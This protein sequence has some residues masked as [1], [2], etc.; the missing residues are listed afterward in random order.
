LNRRLDDAG[1]LRFEYRIEAVGELPVPIPNEK[2]NRLRSRAECPCDLPRLLSDPLGVWMG[3]A[4]SEVHGATGD[5]DEEQHVQT[6]QP[7]R[8]DREEIHRDHT[9]RLRPQELAPRGPAPPSSRSELFLTQRLL[10]GRRRYDDAEPFQFTNDTLVAP[11]RIF[12]SEPKD[13]RSHLKVDRRSPGWSAVRPPFRDEA[14]VP[15]EQR[16]GRNEKGS[17][18]QS[19]QGPTRCR[20]E[21]S[22]S[23]PKRRPLHAP[24][25]HRQLVAQ[26]DDF[27]FLV[28]SRSEQKEDQ[29]Q[30]AVQRDIKDR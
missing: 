14:A 30:N 9:R 24:T 3:R 11:P 13:Q 21:P 23:R 7:H 22:V 26:D 19:W 16:G 29:L 28:L 27:K 1:A 5:W 6:A 8:V 4:P 12:A 2:A 18:P 25:Q 17:P 20:Q 10:D 15:T